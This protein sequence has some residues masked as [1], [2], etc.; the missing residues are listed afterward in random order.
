[1]QNSIW[2]GGGRETQDRGVIYVYVWLNHIDVRQKPTQHCKAII[3][4]LKI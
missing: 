3:L 4:Q 1:M 2:G